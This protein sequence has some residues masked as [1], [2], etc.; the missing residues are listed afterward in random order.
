MSLWL[1]RVKT[2]FDNPPATA[3]DDDHI[4]YLNPIF[5]A[6]LFD[7]IGATDAVISGITVVPTKDFPRTS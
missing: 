1:D 4:A 2:Y 5:G 6:E 7:A 3:P